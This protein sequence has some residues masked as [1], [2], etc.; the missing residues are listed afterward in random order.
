[1]TCR[2]KED[3]DNARMIRNY[4]SAVR[5]QNELVGMNSRL[6]ELQAGLLRVKLQYI[7][8][9]NEERERIAAYYNANISNPLIKPLATRPGSNNVWHQYVIHSPK[10]DELIKFLNSKEIG[11]IIHYPIPP[12][13]SNAYKYL[14]YHEG[15]FPIA[16]QYANEVLSIPMYNGITK[17]EQDYVIAALNSFKG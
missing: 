15:S 17:E 12:H 10:R 4:G 3:A 11:N 5:Y 16:E 6:D 13:L 1:M 8:E 2:D 9:F 7:D 14:G